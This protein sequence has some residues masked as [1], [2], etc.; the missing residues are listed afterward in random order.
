[1]ALRFGLLQAFAP[2]KA[3]FHADAQSLDTVAK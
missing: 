3:G 1:M 2:P